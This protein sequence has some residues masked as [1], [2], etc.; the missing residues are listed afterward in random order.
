MKLYIHLLTTLMVASTLFSCQKNDKEIDPNQLGESNAPRFYSQD[1]TKVIGN[2]WV[3]G[4]QV[5]IFMTKAGQAIS[6]E[7][8]VLGGK[9]VAHVVSQA[10]RSCSF[11]AVN[12][13]EG[14]FFPANGDHVDFTAYYPYNKDVSG[15]IYPIDLSDQ[16]NT[17]ALDL[18]TAKAT[19]KH[20]TNPDVPLE[21]GHRLSKL[22]VT[23]KANNDVTDDIRGATIKVEGL[24]SKG[25]LDLNTGQITP[26]GQSE[27][28]ISATID[29]YGYATFI[30]M[31]F[32][33]G[34][35]TDVKIT[36]TTKSGLTK[37]YNIPH[38]SLLAG[39]QYPLLYDIQN[40]PDAKFRAFLVSSLK[41]TEQDG[42]INPADPANRAIIEAATSLN[43]SRQE[44]LT[45][46]GIEHFTN[47][48]SL[49]CSNNF[50]ET[51]DLSTMPKL[52]S[53]NCNK[54]KLSLIDISGHLGLTSLDCGQNLI[55]ILDVS[56]HNAI[57]D[58]RCSTNSIAELVLPPNGA[59][60]GLY[61]NENSLVE[62]SI[63]EGL[64]LTTLVC[65]KNQLTN[66]DV[67]K[68][69][70]LRLLQCAKNPLNE[71]DIKANINLTDLRCYK[72]NL[73]SLDVSA[74][75][76]LTR[77]H[78]YENLMLGLDITTLTNAYEIWCG[79]KEVKGFVLTLTQDQYDNMWVG[80][81][82]E[83]YY[84]NEFVKT[85]IK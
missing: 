65:D 48:T 69:T 36:I 57:V 30:V 66:I 1:L 76:K 16:S 11:A 78:S 45:V 68:I 21:F 80:S 83:G 28:V 85:N 77:I 32:E 70:S 38:S 44:I 52:T 84:D 49:N 53:L 24:P 26:D 50:I 29:N 75:T 51:L 61:C 13:G 41:L 42:D 73:T 33:K 60:E 37:Q 47:L 19:D 43:C 23:V 46:Q 59:L 25:A 55:K 2:Q 39:I 5:G 81:R 35:A 14:V 9:N 10:G 22:D 54:N 72:C 3:E 63:P 40:F 15:S 8:I 71:L 4:D 82:N 20:S 7:S 79:N 12:K 31:P 62:L 34:Q 56:Q 18:M 67:S 27:K 74:N 64:A 58:L 6:D 17:Q